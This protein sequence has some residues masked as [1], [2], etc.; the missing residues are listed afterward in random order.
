M[1]AS[2]AQRLL[3]VQRMFLFVIPS[4]VFNI[5]FLPG[6]P[7]KDETPA[8]QGRRC[9]FVLRVLTYLPLATH[10]PSGLPIVTQGCAQEK[11]LSE[12]IS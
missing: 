8:C 6:C 4:E 2:P 10:S 12:M 5:N 11:N 9:S 3:P 7:L 1:R